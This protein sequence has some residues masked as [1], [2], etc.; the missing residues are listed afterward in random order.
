L[1]ET[2]ADWV[3][4]CTVGSQRCAIPLRSVAETMR[5]LPVDRIRG[6]PPFVIGLSMIR[7][8]PV[9][10]LDAG[11][12]VFGVD[13][14]ADAGRF[15]TLDLNGRQVGLA[16]TSVVGIRLLPAQASSLPPLLG[17]EAASRIEAVARLD[18]ELHVVLNEA[19]LL[20]E[21]VWAE[22]EASPV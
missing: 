17:G 8:A 11:L 19:H 16:V 5:P 2:Q 4:V 1:N 7:G 14:A 21:S 6:A 20:P 22:L 13:C 12:L 18:S 9:P 15:V 10:V 3:L